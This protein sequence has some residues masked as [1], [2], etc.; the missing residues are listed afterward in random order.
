MN[1]RKA[2]DMMGAYLYGDLST[3]DMKLLRLHVA[4][5]AACR[6]DLESR[7]KTIAAIPNQVAEL[8]VDDRAWIASA[9]RAR[10]AS[11]PSR[12]VWIMPRFSAAFGVAAVI[13]AGIVVGSVLGQTGSKMLGG[14]RGAGE[15]AQVEIRKE[16]KPVGAKSTGKP[17][18]ASPYAA[19][20]SE[21]DVRGILDIIRGA[22]ALGARH[23][24]PRS[25]LGHNPNGTDEPNMVLDEKPTSEV[26]KD[27]VAPNDQTTPSG[28]GLPGE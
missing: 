3:S 15:R 19:Q 20:P 7:G 10:L 4:D 21:R 2:R 8:T 1:C 11:R 26:H 16:I 12:T 22:P 17:A 5:C 23:D 28:T 13:L 27:E 6:Q 25:P 14:Q 9:T 18:V 24:Q